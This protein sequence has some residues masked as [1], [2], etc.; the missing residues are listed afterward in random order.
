M[1]IQVTCA[2]CLKRFEVSDKFAGKQGPCPGCK[3]TITVP[4][5]SEEVVVHAPEEFGDG[6]RDTSGNLLLKPIERTDAKFSPVMAVG[7]AVGFLGLFVVA[8]L[9]R[10]M[11]A[12]MLRTTFMA[13]GAIGLAPPLVWA[14]YAFLR[15]AELAPYQ[16]SQLNLRVA[17]C[18]GVYVVLWLL[19]AIAK[20]Y[21][22][23][24][25][26][27]AVDTWMWVLISVPFVVLGAITSLASFDFDFFSG[28]I[29][30]GLYLLVTI[31]LR[32]TM[33]VALY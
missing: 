14:G 19:F 13:I 20:S 6:G 27:A 1:A 22:G 28:L 24:D 31:A 16:G 11:D 25:D 3:E 12:G 15:D 23:G 29:H 32:Y 4:A 2:S 5:K 33:G 9:L 7:V 21:L 30:Y 18:A 17:I 10:G 8:W 26:P